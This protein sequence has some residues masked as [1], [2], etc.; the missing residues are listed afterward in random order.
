MAV[1]NDAP[2][3]ATARTVTSANLL[4]LDQ[5]AF[6]ALFSHLPPVRRMFER[7]IDQRMRGDEGEMTA[8]GTG[9][10]GR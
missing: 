6:N 10:T 9:T 3:M 1:V 7:L 8:L 5:D 2:R 4:S